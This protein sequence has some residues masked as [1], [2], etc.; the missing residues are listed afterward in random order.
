MIVQ[1]PMKM[2]LGPEG[3][4]QIT[5]GIKCPYCGRELRMGDL[6]TCPHDPDGKYEA[7]GN[8]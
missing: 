3:I 1:Y 7:K 8:Q 6:P 5:L 4:I 2:V